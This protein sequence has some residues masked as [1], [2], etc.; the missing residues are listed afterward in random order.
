MSAFAFHFRPAVK[1]RPPAPRSLALK[2]NIPPPPPGSDPAAF[3]EWAL[4]AENEIEHAEFMI[5][6]LGNDLDNITEIRDNAQSEID[7]IAAEIEEWR[8]HAE[9][10]R[11]F[12]EENR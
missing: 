10:W 8:Q 5:T 11:R 7:R 4:Q 9:Q 12:A 6:S 2:R 1:A 3:R